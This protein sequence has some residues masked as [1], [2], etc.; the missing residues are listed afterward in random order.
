MLSIDHDKAASVALQDSDRQML[1]HRRHL[2]LG[3]ARYDNR[4][5]FLRLAVSLHNARERRV[6]GG[7]DTNLPL[8][9]QSRENA[10]RL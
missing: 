2:D 10:E 1:L 5:A 7:G 4:H 9:L 8:T 6:G 3:V